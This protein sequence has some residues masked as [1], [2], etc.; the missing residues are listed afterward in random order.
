MRRRLL[1]VPFTVEI[2]PAERDINLLHKLEAEWP[3]ILRWCLNGCLQ[4][5]QMGLAPPEIVRAAT[6][7]Y[8][9]DQDTLQQWLDD[10]THDGGPRAFTRSADL[11][12]SWKEWCEERNLKP[13]S[14]QMLAE[15]LADRGHTK[16]RDSKG[17]RGFST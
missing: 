17:R 10:C 11:F 7:N 9:R 15:A 5:Q 3:A 8:F 4:W 2:P 1:L 13:G 14:E 16:A 12:G 6:D